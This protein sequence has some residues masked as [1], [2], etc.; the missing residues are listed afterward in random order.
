MLIRAYTNTQ[1]CHGRMQDLLL[2]AKIEFIRAVIC[3]IGE[4]KGYKFFQNLKYRH[5]MT[6]LLHI[7]YCFRLC[8]KQNWYNVVKEYR[9][10]AQ[11][12]QF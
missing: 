5:S 2:I 8:K 10:I 4:E 12:D 11:V 9:T 1:L 7:C 3:R 6:L